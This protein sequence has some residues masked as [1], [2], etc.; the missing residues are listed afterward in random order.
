MTSC[1][2]QKSSTC[3]FADLLPVSAKMNHELVLNKPE[4]QSWLEQDHEV[5]INLDQSLLFQARS[6]TVAGSG[7]VSIEPM[8]E[9]D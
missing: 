5:A 9:M 8:N 7:H 6:L 2:A 4:V 1:E 3:A